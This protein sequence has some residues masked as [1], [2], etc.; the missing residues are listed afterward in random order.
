MA[1]EIQVMAWCDV[2][3]AEDKR[4]PMASSHDVVLDGK[5]FTV[6]LCEEHEVA[7]YKPFAGLVAHGSAPAPKA[8]HKGTQQALGA[9]AARPVH[10][11]GSRSDAAARE[12]VLCG[13]H[14]AS[15]TVHDRH[16]LQAHNVPGPVALYGLG[17]PLCGQG[18][19]T[20][21]QGLGAHGAGAHQIY[22]TSALYQ[23]AKAAG[24]PHGAVAALL[25]RVV[26]IG[27]SVEPLVEVLSREDMEAQVDREAQQAADALRAAGLATPG[28]KGRGDVVMAALGGIPR[29]RAEARIR[30]AKELG[31]L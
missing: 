24:D 1:R 11:S 19:F 17:C 7:L 5:A 29:S 13:A 16:I 25:E 20:S 2:D 10:R 21:A 23:A 15:R 6:D 22:D 27:G 9:S 30:R 8:P 26:A 18:D 12:C 3:L 14:L 28:T 4:V 31:L